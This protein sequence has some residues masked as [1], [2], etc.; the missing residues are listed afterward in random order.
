MRIL[1]SII[2]FAYLCTSCNFSKESDVLTYTDLN[3]E[4][5]PVI[6][7]ANITGE[8][9]ETG[10]SDITSD[11]EIILPETKEE[12]LIGYAQEIAFY[13]DKLLLSTQVSFPG[14]A[15][16]YMFMRDGRFVREVGKG[17]NGPGE[18]TGYAVLSIQTGEDNLI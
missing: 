17:G 18:H 11:Y 3:G 8:P 13:G 5:L 10:V 16:V 6:H 14:P 2:L 9:E 15:P 4:R 1:Y 12:C 7:F